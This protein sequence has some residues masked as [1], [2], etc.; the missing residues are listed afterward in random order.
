MG[1]YHNEKDKKNIDSFLNGINAMA[2]LL[3]YSA[4]DSATSPAPRLINGEVYYIKIKTA[5]NI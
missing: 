2:N 3:V 1:D 4:S 5:G